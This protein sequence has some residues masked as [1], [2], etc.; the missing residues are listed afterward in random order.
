MNGASNPS[1]SAADADEPTPTEAMATSIDAQRTRPLG[2]TSVVKRVVIVA[3]SGLA[4]YLVLPSITEVL[5]SWPRLSSLNPIWFIAAVAA[6]A[7][8]FGCDFSLQRL[9]LRTRGW[10]AV[11]TAQLT[12]NAVTMPA[13]FGP[14]VSRNSS[15]VA[16]AR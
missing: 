9:A 8:H 6:E 11:I 10:F 15:A 3:V 7:A 14:P 5:A 13:S 4:I 2:W 16:S 1:S 12:G